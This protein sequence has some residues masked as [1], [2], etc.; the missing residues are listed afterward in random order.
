MI[1]LVY[2]SASMTYHHLKNSKSVLADV[3]TDLNRPN[4]IR[5]AARL[6][7]IRPELDLQFTNS[8]EFNYTKTLKGF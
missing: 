5:M 8:I 3:L 4:K 7:S 2:P 6:T 1:I